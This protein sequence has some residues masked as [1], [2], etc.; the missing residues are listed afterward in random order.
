L[1]LDARLRIDG[2][3]GWAAGVF[4][5]SGEQMDLAR[6]EGFAAPRHFVGDGY[7]SLDLVVDVL[8]QALGRD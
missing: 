1:A 7:D 5:V 4:Y 2:S 3:A 8:V 6:E